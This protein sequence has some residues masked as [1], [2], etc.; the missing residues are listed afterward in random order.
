MDFF[1]FYYTPVRVGQVDSH[2]KTLKTLS[3]HV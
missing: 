2:V 1:F 3:I